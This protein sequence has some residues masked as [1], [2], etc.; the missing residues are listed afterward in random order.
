[1]ASELPPGWTLD[2]YDGLTTNDSHWSAW[3]G[4]DAATVC[5]ADD[6]DISVDVLVGEDCKGEELLAVLLCLQHHH[7]ARAE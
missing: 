6:G 1:M 2:R 3:R 7:N 4:R 5:W